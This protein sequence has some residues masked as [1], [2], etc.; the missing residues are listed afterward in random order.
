MKKYSLEKNEA[1]TLLRLENFLTYNDHK[2]FESDLSDLLANLSH[3]FMVD[4]MV[5]DKISNDWLRSLVQIQVALKK[6]SLPMRVVGV[7]PK[8]LALF[9]QEGIDSTF[10]LSPSLKEALIDIGAASKKTLD[11]AFIN[12]FLEATLNVLKVQ[13]NI[14][15][16]PGKIC[17]KKNDKDFRSDISGIIGIVSDTFNGSVIIGF[18]KETFLKVISSML[19]EDFS[20]INK[21]ILD[22]AGEITNMIFGQAK[23]ALNEKGHG[24]KTALPSVVHGQNHSLS[25][26]LKG[27]IVVIPFES[28]AGNF[29]VEICLSN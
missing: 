13:A 15:A 5:V 14:E 10:H 4:C 24:I 9:K 26:E 7:Q 29:Y 25:T 8:L 17:L 6:K 2:E 21:D 12:P 1:Y 11:T 22:G 19:G 27:A 28:T 20:E 3:P 16:R 23:V 18:P